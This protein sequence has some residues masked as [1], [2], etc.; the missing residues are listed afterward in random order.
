MKIR[1]DFVTNSS[2][3]SFILARKDSLSEL[4]RQVIVEYVENEFLGRKVL[5]PQS[6]E[7][8]IEEWLDGVYIN[9][10]ELEEI[11]KALKEGKTIYSEW[12]SFEDADWNY[13]RLFERLWKKLEETEKESFVIIDGDLSY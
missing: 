5:T 10:D 8:D 4:Q 1:T 2:S 3:S 11:R 12:I 9:D 6:T 13:A 7:K